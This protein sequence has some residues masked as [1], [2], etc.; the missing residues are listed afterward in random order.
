M[1]NEFIEWY[2]KYEL[3]TVVRN[4]L[5]RGCTVSIGHSEIQAKVRSDAHV[6]HQPC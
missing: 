3:G 2:V 4:E 6:Q 5:E 1:S